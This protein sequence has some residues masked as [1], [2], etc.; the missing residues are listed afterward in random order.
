LSL[1]S[2]KMSIA[3]RPMLSH[4]SRIQAFQAK[5]S[6]KKPI[7]HDSEDGLLYSLFLRLSLEY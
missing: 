3:I 5:Q 4:I 7:N 2:D 1:S 6:V